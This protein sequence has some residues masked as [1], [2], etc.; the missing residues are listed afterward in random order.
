MFE[1]LSEKLEEAL[2]K[3]RG[4]SKITE[5]NVSDALAEV[6]RALLDADVNL[7][8]VKSFIDSVK[9]KSLGMEVKGNILPGQMM[10]KL[11]HDELVSLM[12]TSKTDITFAPQAPTI[13]MVAGLQGSGKTTFCAKL[14]FQLKKKGRQPLLVACDIY[15][16][17]AIDQLKTL[18]AKMTLPVFSKDDAQPVEI[19]SE[20]LTY[21]R[22]YGR[23]VVIV[24]TA[25]RLTIDEAM[26]Q[27][28][29][30]LKAA[31]KPHE[32][33][34]VCDAMTGQD[35]VNTAQ[36]F[37][38]KLELT[39]VVLTKL[40]GDT[41]GGAAL[42]IRSV[43]GKPIKFVGV[44]ENIDQ[45][46]PFHPERIASR[47]L[48]MGDIITLV[49]KAQ[50]Q[51]DEKEAARLEEKLK[52][53]Q[54]TFEDFLDQMRM[55]KKMG[56]LRDLL[57]ML[58]GM[59]KALRNVQIDERAFARVE[60]IVLSMTLEERRSPKLLNGSRRRRIA[61]GSGTTI[62]DVNRLIKQF[63]DM[64][65]MMKNMSRGK[66]AHLMGPQTAARR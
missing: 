13:V 7:G 19:A 60:A 20:A 42:S 25:G 3:I 65:K 4:Q 66:M 51:I 6:R 27:E 32:V 41:R 63:E 52:K 46:E 38:D 35:A 5:E 62:Q 29:A 36:A 30:D 40:D 12:G 37:H 8:V 45:L 33:L 58:P 54:F 11:I 26:M 48:G 10:I 50:S 16:P 53:N 43:L 44:G 39:G 61:L 64:Q 59:D 49:E 55:I 9:E 23:D 47:I 15:R 31:I 21:A 22:K 56:S 18:G 17:A 14:A 1:S 24:D 57:G 28:V 34:F 2:K